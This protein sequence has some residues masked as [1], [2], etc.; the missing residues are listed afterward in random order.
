MKTEGSWK[1]EL[2]EYWTMPVEAL[3]NVLGA[4][5][6]RGLSESEALERLKLVG[7]NR[8]DAKKR[9]SAFSIFLS[10][11][12]SPIIIILLFATV[13]SAV[14]QSFADSAIILTI[15]FLSAVLGF[16]EEY[17]ANN[18]VEKLQRRV[19]VQCKVIREGREQSIPMEE[20]VPG[21]VVLL[22]VGS[23][24]PGDGI[25]IESNGLFVNQAI[26]TGEDFPAEK[27]PE[28]TNAQSSLSERKNTVFMGTS[29]ANGS[30]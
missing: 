24:I 27:K 5:I 22:S 29:V 26:I 11:F 12:K 16:F 20:I 25:V 1:E 13:V 2:A 14:V 9:F 3:A 10:Q 18:A 21:D 19:S 4:N 28:T 6:A 23:L 17:S 7:L 30:G 15:V 8:L